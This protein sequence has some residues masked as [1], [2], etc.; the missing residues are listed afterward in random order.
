MYRQTWQ[1]GCTELLKI[2]GMTNALVGAV[3]K[4]PQVRGLVEKSFGQ[5]SRNGQIETSPVEGGQDC[6]CWPTGAVSP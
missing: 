2:W 5:R 4:C 1:L 6:Y 3:E